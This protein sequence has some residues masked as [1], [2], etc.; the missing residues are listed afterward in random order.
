MGPSQLSCPDIQPGGLDEQW[1]YFAFID[2]GWVQW[3]T[4]HAGGEAWSL[5][6]VLPLLSAVRA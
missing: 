3:C 4:A 2:S 6:A 5:Q 1:M